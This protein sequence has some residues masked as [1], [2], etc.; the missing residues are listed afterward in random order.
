MLVDCM[1]GM[2]NFSFSSCSITARYRQDQYSFALPLL[3][4]IRSD[5]SINVARY[6]RTNASAV[7]LQGNGYIDSATFDAPEG[8][9]LLVD[10]R[11]TSATMGINKI[12]QLRLRIRE[13]APLNKLKLALPLDANATNTFAYITGRFDVLTEEDSKAEHLLRPTEYNPKL[14]DHERWGNLVTLEQVETGSKPLVR[15][16]FVEIKTKTG[17]TVAMPARK[18]RLIKLK[19][20]KKCS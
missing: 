15:T 8:S 16:K 13:G 4:A 9:I 2:A 5:K 11:Y 7:Q 1:W 3:T 18:A 14:L 20:D 6:D 17:N 19:G 12:I 10:Y